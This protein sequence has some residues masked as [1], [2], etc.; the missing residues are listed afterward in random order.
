MSVKL[1]QHPQEGG[2]HITLTPRSPRH[3]RTLA[4]ALATALTL[5]LISSVAIAQSGTIIAYDVELETD[6]FT[7][8]E[9]CLQFIGNW[10]GD[11]HLWGFMPKHSS[12]TGYTI[13]FGYQVAWRG[14]IYDEYILRE[15]DRILMR[16]GDDIYTLPAFNAWYASDTNTEGVSVEVPRAL[17]HALAAARNPVPVRLES[18]GSGLQH[19]V[20]LPLEALREYQRGFARICL[21]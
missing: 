7:S 5:T 11:T 18:D 13:T 20:T 21:P 10:Q 19:D 2:N 6:P 14:L 9:S 8:E 4:I 17:F 3:T 16:V 15:Q 1:R 12:E